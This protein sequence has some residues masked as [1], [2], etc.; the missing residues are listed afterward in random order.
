MIHPSAVIEGDVTI[1]EGCEIGPHCTIRGNVTLGAGNR[2]IA[3]VHLSGPLTIGEGNIMFPGCCLGFAPQDVGFPWD[4]PGAGLEI[5]SHNTFR[6][7]VAI[8]RAKTDQ[9]TRV[10]NHTY[11][12]SCSHAGHDCQVGDR[13]IIGSGSLLAGHVELADRVLMSGNT[14]LH[15]FVRVGTGAMLSGHAGSVRDV[16]PW[17]TVTTM[18]FCGSVNVVGLRRNGFTPEQIDTVRWIYRTLCLS[19]SLPSTRV[20]AVRERAGDPLVDEYLRF[21]DASKRGLCLRGGR[22]TGDE[23]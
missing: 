12:M 7:G 22:R 16:L 18:N 8:H 11:W 19:K 4:K 14:S 13:C 20:A 23:G 1:G 21:I 10:G 3:G 17:F 5:G 9:P 15:Q 6:E 2:L